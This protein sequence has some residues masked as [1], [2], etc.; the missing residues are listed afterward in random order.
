MRTLLSKRHK[1]ENMTSADGKMNS[2]MDVAK[3]ENS[4]LKEAIEHLE[5]HT[6]EKFL[7]FNGPLVSFERVASPMDL[8]KKVESLLHLEYAYKL[9][10][11]TI[12]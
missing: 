1:I 8:F 2:E 12:L 7:I 5:L 6:L 9:N 11:S 10:P 3:R 4:D